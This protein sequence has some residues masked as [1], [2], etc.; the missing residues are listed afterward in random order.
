MRCN[1]S[2][3]TIAAI[4]LISPPANPSAQE[5]LVAGYSSISPVEITLI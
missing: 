1:L 2:L 4:L 3:L 5:K